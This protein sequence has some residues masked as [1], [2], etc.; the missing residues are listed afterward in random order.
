MKTRILLILLAGLLPAACMQDPFALDN[1]P[2]A[3]TVGYD[4]ES[5]TRTSVT[6]T[7]SLQD[8]T[9]VAEYGFELAE[10]SFS[11]GDFAVFANPPKDAD[12]SFS[13]SVSLKPGAFYVLR[14][15]VSNGALK[16]Y[17]PEITLKAPATAL[18]TVSEVTF[19][20]GL[21]Q[22]RV[23]DDG[24][25]P[26]HEVGFCWG[27]NP[28]PS[29][30]RRNRIAATRDASGSF[31]LNVMEL[32]MGKTY[33]IV[34]Y[35]ENSDDA[36]EAY[37]YSD[38]PFRLELTD[39]IPVPIEDPAFASYLVSKFDRDRDG[40]LSYREISV[41]T[42][43]Q[44]STDQIHSL[45]GIG[46]MPKLSSLTC[47]GSSS[48]SGQLE[49][50]DLSRNGA[51]A[52]LRCG[53]NRIASLDLSGNPRLT[54]VAIDGNP[55]SELDISRCPDLTTLTALRC[56]QLATIYVAPAFTR[57]THTGFKL[58]RTTSYALAPAAPI[59]FPDAN[60]RRYLVEQ[61]DKDG[62]NQISVAESAVITRIDVCTDHVVSLS[63]IEFLEKLKELRCCG[64]ESGSGR[65]ESLD[66]SGNPL[67]EVLH[68]YGNP[69]LAKIWLKTGQTIGDFLYD[70]SVSTLNYK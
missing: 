18:A 63:G 25:R 6:L 67:L 47:T 57:Q 61:F 60:L 39:D 69:S 50:L 54:Q 56:A 20:D 16:K 37:G 64:S 70:S 9:P 2:Q 53:N 23:L 10:T 1:E 36:A 40:V 12:N 30:I 52:I 43:I 38:N 22:A 27:E 68:C 4:A 11:G 24:G 41:I 15:Y 31:S 42:T 45:K 44:V 32:E 33:Y 59:P 55:L 13:L 7:G 48:G 65:L 8:A 35:A 51:L 19:A 29:V 34:A 66:V 46:M 21:L 17:S 62:D 5:L 14:A 49:A 3:P 26:V 28:Y 58:E